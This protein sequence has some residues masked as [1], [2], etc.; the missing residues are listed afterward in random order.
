MVPLHL[1][2]QNLPHRTKWLWKVGPQM[3]LT[4]VFQKRSPLF[5]QEC[6]QQGLHCTLEA[7]ESCM[8]CA[9]R[10]IVIKKLQTSR[11]VIS[12]IGFVWRITNLWGL[13]V[14]KWAEEIT[15]LIKKLNE[16]YPAEQKTYKPERILS[17]G[18]GAQALCCSALKVPGQTFKNLTPL[19]ELDIRMLRWLKR[20]VT[21]H[22]ASHGQAYT[23]IS[24]LG[25]KLQT[26]VKQ[27]ISVKDLISSLS[28]NQF[29][30]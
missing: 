1:Q 12:S 26:T 20:V 24:M 9:G 18:T 27:E 30:D 5:Y 29:S 8:L 3:L 13:Y 16:H 25:K 17:K 14:V 2:L 7:H 19:F 15:Y 28:S 6:L 10:L 4:Q 11:L 22:T 21:S 23:P